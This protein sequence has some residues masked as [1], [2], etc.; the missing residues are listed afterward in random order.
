M[1]NASDLTCYAV[2]G[3]CPTQR[4]VEQI[5]AHSYGEMAQSF[6]C[7]TYKDISEVINS[8]ANPLYWCNQNPDHQEFAY[9]FQEINP[10]DPDRVYP[11]IT[12]RII[13][14]ASGQCYQYDIDPNSGRKVN[15]LNGDLAAWNW[16]Y[17]N[18]TVNGNVTIPTLYSADD[19]TT[20][21]YRGIEIPQNETEY[22]CGPRCMWMWAFKAHS[23]LP[24]D[25]LNQP[26]AIYQCPITISPV[27]NVTNSTQEISDGMARVA[28]SSIALQGRYVNV[29]NDTI[30]TQYQLY[31]W[32]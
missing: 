25:S 10:V 3:E 19:S 29:G 31:P 22:A 28:A 11:R 27:T 20:Y 1:V 18:G 32:G 7:R 13:T 6:P 17:S 14:A 9:R 24:A 30:W 15:D 4:D 16:S 23:T 12:N 8:D 21:I 26:V 5:T 2:N